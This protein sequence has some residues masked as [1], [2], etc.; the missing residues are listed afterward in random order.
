MADG[1]LPSMDMRSR[2]YVA[3][4]QLPILPDHLTQSGLGK[5]VMRLYQHPKETLAN[6][7]LLREIIEKWMRLVIGRLAPGHQNLCSFSCERAVVR[8]RSEAIRIVRGASS[9]VA[10]F[11]IHRPVFK[12]T[13]SYR[14]L[15][16]TVPTDERTPEE[17][18]QRRKARVRID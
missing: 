14:D 11:E 9:L 13:A 6:R 4:K 1:S 18:E 10:G 15:Q 5:V 16:H 12:A 3:L 17:L 8:P 7:T 2:L